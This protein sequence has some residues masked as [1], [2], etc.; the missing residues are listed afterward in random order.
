MEKQK[1]NNITEIMT[2]AVV[3]ICMLLI[4]SLLKTNIQ[5]LLNF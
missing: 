1:G 5:H 2:I 3:I 4:I